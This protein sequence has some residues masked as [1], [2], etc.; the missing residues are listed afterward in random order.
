[1]NFSADVFDLSLFCPFRQDRGHRYFTAGAL[2][3]TENDAQYMTMRG[4]RENRSRQ[5]AGVGILG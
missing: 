4:M 1:M 3:E 2:K 5:R